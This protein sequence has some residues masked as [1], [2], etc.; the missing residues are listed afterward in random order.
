ML[1]QFSIKL[2]PSWVRAEGRAASH[3]VQMLW[4]KRRGHDTLALF[5]GYRWSAP[6][7][8][9]LTRAGPSQY[10]SFFTWGPRQDKRV[11][12]EFLDN[13]VAEGHRPRTVASG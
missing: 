10:S 6:C 7:Q 5:N 2:H 13:S 3:I 1:L 12:F 11:H 9:H 4:G 8:K